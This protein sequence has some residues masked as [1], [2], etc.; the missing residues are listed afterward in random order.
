MTESR[1]R[2][3]PDR[4]LVV[5]DGENAATWL[6]NLVAGDLTRLEAETVVFTALLSPQGKVL[7]EFFV[8]IVNGSLVLDVSESQVESL[9]K[10]LQMY[11]LRSRV[12]FRDATADWAVAWGLGEPPLPGQGGAVALDPRVTGGLWRA[13]YP[14]SGAP[15]DVDEK[16][17]RAARVHLGIGEAPDDYPLGDVFPHEINMDLFGGVSF[18]KGCFVGQEVVSRMQNKTVVRKRLVRVASKGAIASGAEVRVG[19]AVIGRVG[20]MADGGGLAML[21]LD[22]VAEAL[23]CGSAISAS[24]QTINVEAAA[25]DRY[26]QSVKDKPVVDL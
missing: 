15:L 19:D 24:G 6:D 5:V 13:L 18:S 7:F 17:Y 23:E 16:A 3:I 8:W 26:R 25:L 21:R 2:V 11:R 9:T 20:T 1:T 14:R 12:S 22:R 4:T 10:R